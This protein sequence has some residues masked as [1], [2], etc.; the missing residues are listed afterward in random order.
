MVLGAW[1]AFIDQAEAVDLD[2]PSRL[3]GWR[4]HEICVHLGCWDDHHRHRRPHRLGP[5]RRH[6]HPPGRRRRQRRVTARA[7]GRLPRGGARRP[8]AQPRGD[9]PL[10]AEEP[11]EL[12]TAPGGLGRRPAAPAQRRPRAGLR[13]RR[14]RPGPGALRRATAPAARCCSRGWPR[15][16]T[17]PARSRRPAASPAASTLATPDGG[18][19]FAADGDGW[20][21]RRTAPGRHAVAPPSRRTPTCCSRRPRGASIRCRRWR[22]VGSSVHEVGGLLRSRRSC[23]RCPASRAG[24]SSSSPPAPWAG[25]AACSGGCSD[26]A[27]DPPTTTASG[28]AT[29]SGRGP[30]RAGRND[31]TPPDR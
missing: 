30:R 28:P 9:R 4:A 1:D 27:R 6:R 10:P 13:A 14:P 26:A 21:V 2:R 29:S 22:A 23:R 25:R 3:P 31:R 17:S 24:R 8:A 16:P 7:P 11:V 18:W 12:D 5:R 19:A 15:S 20:T